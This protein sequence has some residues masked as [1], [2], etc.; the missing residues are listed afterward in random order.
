M[1]L[2]FLSKKI[3]KNRKTPTWGTKTFRKIIISGGLFIMMSIEE[4]QN[5][6]VRTVDPETLVD[7]NRFISGWILKPRL[8]PHN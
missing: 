3:H 2:Q 8:I 6:D 4:M 1:N 7:S 5:I